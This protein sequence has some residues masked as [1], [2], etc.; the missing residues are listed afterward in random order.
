MTAV[1]FLLITA[2][3]MLV[4]AGIRGVSLPHELLKVF[5]G[6]Q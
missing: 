5:G 2:G 4:Y 3:F 6:T 1:A